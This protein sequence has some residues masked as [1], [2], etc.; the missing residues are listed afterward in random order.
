MHGKPLPTSMVWY[1]CGSFI[2]LHCS[3][4]CTQLRVFKVSVVSLSFIS[5]GYLESFSKWLDCV[6]GKKKVKVD[7]EESISYVKSVTSLK[8]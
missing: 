8:I 2:G 3:D 5:F 6:F 1:F 4:C 7:E